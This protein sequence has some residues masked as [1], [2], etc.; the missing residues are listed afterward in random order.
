MSEAETRDEKGRFLEGSPGGP[1]RPK[2]SKSLSDALRR[3]LKA[4]LGEDELVKMMEV[5]DLTDAQREMLNSMENRLDVL[6][7]LLILR[8]LSGNLDTFKEI[9]DRL[10]P[11]PRRTEISG[12]GGGPVRSIAAPVDIGEAEA[13]RAYHDALR[14]EGE[15]E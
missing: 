5:F 7:E 2:G 14:G 3:R 13:E 12:P 6:A 11:K 4:G 1:G 8:A 9:F 10:D 15:N